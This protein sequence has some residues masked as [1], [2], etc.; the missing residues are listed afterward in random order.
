V[1]VLDSQPKGVFDENVIAAVS[2]WI[3]DSADIQG[4]KVKVQLTQRIE[5]F[6]KDYPNNNTQLK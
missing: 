1:R 4:R 5:L 3:Y 2:D 6:W